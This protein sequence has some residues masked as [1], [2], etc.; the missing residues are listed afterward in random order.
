MRE[1][2][3]AELR[4]RGIDDPGEYFQS[5]LIEDR[6]RRERERLGKMLQEGLDSEMSEMT[7]DDWREIR[8]EVHRR[9]AEANRK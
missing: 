1:F 6:K 4:E 3:D 2:L 9:H 7:E 8:E 5:L